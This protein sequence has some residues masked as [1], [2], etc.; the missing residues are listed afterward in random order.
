M[1]GT[2][3]V[4]KLGAPSKFIYLYTS[5]CGWI[6]TLYFGITWIYHG[7]LLISP[8]HTPNVCSLSHKTRKSML[9][10]CFNVYVLVIPQ[11][12]YGILVI[13]PD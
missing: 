8:G 6:K 7:W 4:A 12:E 2:K 9:G 11:D 10:E 13:T 3:D 1:E 5:L